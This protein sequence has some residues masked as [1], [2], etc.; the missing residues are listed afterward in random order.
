MDLA[1]TCSITVLKKHVKPKK[2]KRNFFTFKLLKVLNFFTW[3]R[4]IKGEI[5]YVTTECDQWFRDLWLLGAVQTFS[6]LYTQ[7]N[8]KN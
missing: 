8:L 6:T 7:Q 5:D 1:L 4:D 3:S 2:V